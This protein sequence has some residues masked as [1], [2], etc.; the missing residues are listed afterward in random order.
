MIPND[1]LS[2]SRLVQRGLKWW[3]QIL[4]PMSFNIMKPWPYYSS[5]TTSPDLPA[6]LSPKHSYQPV[7]SCFSSSD[8]QFWI[9]K[10]TP[11]TPT[12]ILSSLV[13]FLMEEFSSR[14]SSL[15]TS[16]SSTPP[17]EYEQVQQQQQQSVAYHMSVNSLAAYET[18]DDVLSSAVILLVFW[19]FG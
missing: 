17:P 5:P 18:R 9:W 15:E 1:I 4:F 3:F 8:Y 14:S 13:H 11:W 19:F 2:G 7:A 6:S 10:T 12:L 16:L